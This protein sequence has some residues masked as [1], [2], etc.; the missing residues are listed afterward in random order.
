MLKD[1]VEISMQTS[2]LVFTLNYF[3]VFRTIHNTLTKPMWD[4]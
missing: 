1:E 2:Y 3:I 4:I